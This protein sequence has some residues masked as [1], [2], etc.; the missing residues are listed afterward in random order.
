MQKDGTWGI[1]QRLPDYI[2]TPEKEESV[3]IH[4]DGKT[5]YFAS[6]GH[7]GMGGS[8]LYI[9]RMDANGK[10]SKPENLGFPINTKYDENSLMVSP[11]GEIAFFASDREG[12]FG[13]LDIYFFEMPEELRPTKTLYFEGLVYDIKT[14]KPIEGEFQLIDLETGKEVVFSKADKI[15]GEFMV[16][17]PVNKDYALNVNYPGYAFFSQNFNMTN[18]ENLE[19]IHMD[20]PMV[21]LT[22]N[23]DAIV[24][25]NVFFDL[26]KST[27]RKESFIE[28]DKLVNF[29]R[30]NPTVKIEI[31]GHTDSR[32]DAAKNKQ[33]SINRAKSVYNYVIQK[34]IDAKR[35]SYAGYGS[36]KPI[37]SEDEIANMKDNKEKEEAHQANRR[38]EY[39]IIQ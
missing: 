28:L 3:L 18:P 26:N 23:T 13:D 4:P 36:T 20:I 5:L 12:G 2:N 8:D 10:W 21:P 15:T 1:A 14:R 25:A 17:L 22:N 32:G 39:K 35:L 30:E 9:S 11:D 19:A 24:L 16:S 33:L 34:G 37:Y 27:L 31:G 29:L 7:V 6:R 38:T